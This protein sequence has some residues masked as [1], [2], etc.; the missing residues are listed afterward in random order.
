MNK[1]KSPEGALAGDRKDLSR[2]GRRPVPKR[3]AYEEIP[4]RVFGFRR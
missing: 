1:S 2:E 3:G 4:V